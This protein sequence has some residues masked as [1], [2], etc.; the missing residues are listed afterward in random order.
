MALPK[1]LFIS[2]VVLFGLIGVVAAVRKKTA[3]R[4]GAEIVQEVPL[5]SVSPAS[6]VQP[7][8]SRTHRANH[9]STA[10]QGGDRERRP[11]HLLPL[12]WSSI[13][14]RRRSHLHK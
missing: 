5:S 7:S 10:T 13:H 9:F 4:P 14:R 2:A 8:T 1:T 6:V 3:S 12:R 11:P